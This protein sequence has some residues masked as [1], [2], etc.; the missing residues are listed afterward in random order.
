VSRSLGSIISPL[1]VPTTLTRLLCW[2][3]KGGRVIRGRTQPTYAHGT[4][5]P[6]HTQRAEEDT[7]K[8]HM[9]GSQRRNPSNVPRQHLQ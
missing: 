3:K 6:K 7:H 2:A 5:S 8:P 4:P 1:L 9:P